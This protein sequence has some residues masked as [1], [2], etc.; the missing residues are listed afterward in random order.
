MAGLTVERFGELLRARHGAGASAYVPELPPSARRQA[1]RS[2]VVAVAYRAGGRVYEYRGTLGQ[3][4]GRLGLIP[5]VDVPTEARRLAAALMA[6]QD[7]LGA[8]EA[9]DTLRH[10]LH[11][12]GLAGAWS[13]L[14]YEAAGSDEY[15]REQRRYW[16]A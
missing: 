16:L 1:R 4:A 8:P 3:V 15:G 10:L 9:V 6:G 14:Q 11:E 5:A 12:R 2:T 13:R 7:V